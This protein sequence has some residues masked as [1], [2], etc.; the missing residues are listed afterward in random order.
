MIEINLLPPEILRHKKIKDF[1]IFVII[2]VFP[3]ILVCIIFSFSLKEVAISVQKELTWA[4]GKVSEYQ[5]VLK[6]LEELK[7]KKVTLEHRLS[8]IRD[9]VVNRS[10]WPLVLYEIS[11]SLPDS[12]WLTRLTKNVQGKEQIITIEG[13]SLNQTVDIGKFVENLNNK[14]SLFEEI[15]ISIVSKSNIG[16][17]EVMG[18]TIS[19]KIK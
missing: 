9:L 15:A 14:S 16:K 19:G 17:T 5:P 2:S 13:F 7:N 10:S 3:V 12:I 8:T 6:E 4:R 11:D 1:L 18:F